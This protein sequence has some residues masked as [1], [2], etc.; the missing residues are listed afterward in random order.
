MDI[1]PRRFTK[2]FF[3]FAYE[4][5]FFFVPTVMQTPNSYFLCFYLLPR[6]I[7]SDYFHFFCGKRDARFSCLLYVVFLFISSRPY[8]AL[9]ISSR[10][11]HCYFILLLHNAIFPALLNAVFLRYTFFFLCY[12]ISFLLPCVIFLRAHYLDHSL[13]PV[14]FSRALVR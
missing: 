9:T 12:A 2:H 10:L 1:S 7:T 5:A 4:I 11:V 8:P 3:F 14:I 6:A 13:A